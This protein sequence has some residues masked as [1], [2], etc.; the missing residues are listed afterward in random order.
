MNK[1]MVFINWLAQK[2]KLIKAE[3]MFKF[4]PFFHKKTNLP[5]LMISYFSEQTCIDL[6]DCNASILT[7]RC[8]IGKK[9]CK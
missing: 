4:I 1:N 3:E 6:C 7:V 2:A 9:L 8:F 5:P